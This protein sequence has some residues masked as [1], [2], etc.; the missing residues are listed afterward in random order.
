MNLVW[1]A[2]DIPDSTQAASPLLLMTSLEMELLHSS[3]ESAGSFCL[4]EQQ[5]H[6]AKTFCFY[7]YAFLNVK[8]L[9]QFP[10]VSAS[11]EPLDGI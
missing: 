3:E 10:K 11:K 6:T 1:W 9:A 4:S 2:C 5:A 7:K 8:G